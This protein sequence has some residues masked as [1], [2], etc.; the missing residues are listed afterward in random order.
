MRIS[1]NDGSEHIDHG[2][3]HIDHG[4]EHRRERTELTLSFDELDALK[5]SAML[6]EIMRS[7]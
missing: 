5:D 1:S 4:S 6:D 2:S 3:N 7:L